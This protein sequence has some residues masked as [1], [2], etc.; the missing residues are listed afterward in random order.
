M[1]PSHIK[2]EG[3]FMGLCA[4]SFKLSFLTLP[5][6]AAMNLL[7][8]D[9][10]LSPPPAVNNSNSTAPA[11]SA[12]P[13]AATTPATSDNSAAPAASTD[14]AAPAASTDSAAPAASTDSAAPAASTTP[15]A[16][17]DSAAPAAPTTPAASTDSAAPAASTTPA[18]STDS[19][20]PAASTTPAA[21]TDSAAP[22]AP[23]TPAASTDSAA[24]AAPTTPAA[25]TD[26]AAPA[27]SPTPA[28]STDSAAPAAPATPAAST[29]STAPAAL[30]TPATLAAP[31]DSATPAAP[32]AP[33]TAPAT[34]TAPA[35]PA[36]STDSSAST[37]ADN[38]SAPPPI[39]KAPKATKNEVAVSGDFMYGDGTVS[40]PLGY[41]LKQSLHSGS[42]PVGAFTVPRNSIYYGATASYS[43]GQAWYLDIS[44]AQG[45]SSGSQNINTG[46]L[47]NMRSTFTLDDT[48]YQGYLRYAF[49]QLR[50]KRLSAYLRVG[51]SYITATLTDN[52][53][54]PATGRYR[55]N[56]STTDI[57]GNIGLG[58][59]Y[60]LYTKGRFRLGLQGDL[61]GFYGERSQ[62]TLETLSA[63]AGVNFVS[64]NINNSLY[65]VLGR[66]TLRGEYRLGQ[67]GLFKLFGD[68]GVQ[69][70]YTSVDYPGAGA[71]AE[72][73]YGLYGKL[74]LRYSF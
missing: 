7:A 63:D 6:L 33:P 25:S 64:A 4:R 52:A 36:A 22:A 50:G 70:Q 31:A 5:V 32:A 26:S 2:K 71:K 55:Q 58:L 21:S 59:G 74:G 73:V 9:Q 67:T 19:A 1:I 72:D 40:L 51:V 49:P 8:Q 15:A 11:D 41:S 30:A 23:T 38:L 61:E 48:Y 29:D 34:P 46:S 69:G 27:A 28:A 37:S 56:D 10:P 43:Y 12:A 54:S 39:L 42:T 66:V 16:S 14:S 45:T 65:G 44:Y 62:S 68:V 24:P 35:P 53:S 47:G 57:L 17:T 3:A 20:A 13:T 18:A 60:S